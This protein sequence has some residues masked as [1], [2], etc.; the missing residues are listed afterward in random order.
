M[1]PSRKDQAA[2]PTAVKDTLDTVALTLQTASI[3]LTYPSLEGDRELDLIADA[4]A[5]SPQAPGRRDV[6]SFLSWWR[7]LDSGERERTYVETFDFG[8]GI[9]LYLTEGR[10]TSRQRGSALLELRRACR[11]AGAA[12]RSDELPDY[13]PLLLEAAA[14]V[15]A[16]RDLLARHR[17]A[18]QALAA[19]LKRSGS[20]FR[21]L[22]DAVLAAIGQA[23]PEHRHSG[24]IR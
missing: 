7:D 11:D 8:T 6:E 12:V 24:G 3:L 9:S 15:P 4:L 23:Q 5:E 13:L 20:H 1:K 2:A 22:V 16:C 19:G 18:L 17:E 10:L 21:L 14:H